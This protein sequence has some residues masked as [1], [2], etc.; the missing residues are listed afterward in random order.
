[1]DGA[2]RARLWSLL[3]VAAVTTLAAA[4][5]FP[6]L[7]DQSYW[8]DEAITVDLLRCDFGAMLRALPDSESTPPLYYVVAWTWAKVFGTGEVGLR[9]LSALCGTAIAPVAYAV[10][11]T[12]SSRRVGVIVAAFAAASPLL[13]WYS[14]EARAYALY[15]LLGALSFLFFAR[16]LRQPSR[17]TLIGWAAVSAL[18]LATHYFAV[19]AVVAE[20]AVLLVLT[21]RRSAVAAASGAVA[22]ASLALLPL[23]LSQEREGRTSWIADS[24]IVDRIQDVGRRF[25]AGMYPL[26]HAEKL[27]IVLLAGAVAFLALRGRLDERRAALVGLGVG[28]TA[29]VLPLMLAL[30]GLDYFLHRNLLA[31]WL[32][33]ALV[34]AVACGAVRAAPVGVAVA[35]LLV[36][37]SVGV[38]AATATRD[39]LARDDWRSVRDTLARGGQKLVIV[40]PA[41]ERTPLEY[42]RPDVR[43]LGQRDFPVSEI[44]LLGYPDEGES[45]PPRN[46]RVPASFRRVETRLLDRVQLVRF[47]AAR[48]VAVDAAQVGLADA[49]PSVLVLLDRGGR[50]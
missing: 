18:A 49:G 42:Y 29:V 46:F 39:D 4:L 22:V 30:A 23:A 10:G 37:A 3:P 43:P 44:V 33:L 1:M 14:Q 27:G 5:R 8:L 36:A 6:T 40:S 15:A 2:R 19:F 34:L 31:A 28:G 11:I 38:V 25:V 45:F 48:R 47:R 32:P 50:R 24:P 26:P 41:F 21:P 7:G 9:A 12:L 16:A 35:A 20:A 17:G 13:V